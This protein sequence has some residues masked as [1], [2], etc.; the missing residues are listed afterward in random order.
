MGTIVRLPG[1]RPAPSQLPEVLR[2]TNFLWY[3]AKSP[4]IVLI[5]GYRYNSLLVK[6]FSS[7]GSFSGVYSRPINLY[8]FGQYTFFSHHPSRIAF[9]VIAVIPEKETNFNGGKLCCGKL[10]PDQDTRT[11]D[12]LTRIHLKKPFKSTNLEKAVRLG[13]HNCKIECHQLGRWYLS[14]LRYMQSTT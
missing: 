10:R 14:N 6:V 3:Q 13:G 2:I 8:C 4:C 9:L 12:D 11:R 1:Y 7:S 5:A